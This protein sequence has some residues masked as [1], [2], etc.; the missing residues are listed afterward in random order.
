M[1]ERQGS[2][3]RIFYTDNGLG[4]AELAELVARVYSPVSVS[5]KGLRG[6]NRSYLGGWAEREGKMSSSQNRDLLRK[7]EERKGAEPSDKA[8]VESGREEGK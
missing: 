4:E 8:R 1:Y 6:E 7:G 3:K 2:S 5:H